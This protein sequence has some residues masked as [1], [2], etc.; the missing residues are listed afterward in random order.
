MEAAATSASVE[1]A[2]SATAMAAASVETAPSAT[3]MAAASAL[4]EDHHRGQG[5]NEDY[6]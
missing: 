6:A 3:A 5:K 1:T 4:R 2:P